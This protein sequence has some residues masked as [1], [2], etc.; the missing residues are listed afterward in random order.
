MR[1]QFDLVVRED[2]PA[3]AEG[4]YRLAGRERRPF[5]PGQ[6][7]SEFVGRMR[8]LELLRTLLDSAVER[9]GQ[10]VGIV[11]EPGIGK[12]RL[13]H[14]FRQRVRDEPVTC[15]EA[16]CLE[17]GSTMP[18]LPILD[19]LRQNCRIVES[20][21]PAAIVEKV[22][23]ALQEV[24]LDPEAE[25]PYLLHLLGLEEGTLTRASFDRDGHDA[26]WTPDGRFIT[27]IAPVNRPDGV[28]LVLLRKRPLSAEPPDTLLASRLLSYTGVWLRDG[29]GLVTTA[30]GLRRDPR[31]SDSAGTGSGADAAIVRNAGRG[32]VEPLVASPFAE[33]FVGVVE[34]VLGVAH[35]PTLDGLDRPLWL[36]ASDAAQRPRVVAA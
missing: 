19:I 13:L 5:G 12:S 29:S 4:I 26:T 32:P 8:E 10:I 25:T 1:R 34:V 28:T 30:A 17:Y 20:D 27:Y 35:Q 31:A 6:R 14:E 2:R 33:Q 15:L 16:H 7:V 11:G 36:G 9:R 22:R 23:S 21:L 24:G 3:G 18:Y